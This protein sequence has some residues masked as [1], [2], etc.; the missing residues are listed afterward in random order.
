MF[1]R[2]HFSRSLI[3]YTLFNRG[4]HQFF[5]LYTQHAADRNGI[6]RATRPVEEDFFRAQRKSNADGGGEEEEDNY[7]RIYG[8]KYLILFQRGNDFYRYHYSRIPWTSREKII[9]KV[10]IGRE[11]EKI[12][13]VAT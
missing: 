13:M 12:Q 10:W 1:L 7:G 6:T 8:E 2:H 11:E 3:V 5:F 4:T 9:K